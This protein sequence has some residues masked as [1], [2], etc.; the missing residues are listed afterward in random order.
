MSSSQNFCVF[1]ET[2]GEY[3]VYQTTK[4][5]EQHYRREKCISRQMLISD[6]LGKSDKLKAKLEELFKSEYWKG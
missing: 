5:L 2:F 6:I 3:K 1:C 4:L